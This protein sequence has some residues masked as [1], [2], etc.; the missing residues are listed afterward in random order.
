M[1]VI[2]SIISSGVDFLRA[3]C[4]ELR[5]SGIPT[6]AIKSVCTP[7]K[8]LVDLRLGGKKMVATLISIAISIAGIMVA[9][10]LID[11]KYLT[12]NKFHV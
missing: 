5:L 8:F 7:G 11:K 12:S 6:V 1:V 3:T 10:A 2:N 9:T 4:K